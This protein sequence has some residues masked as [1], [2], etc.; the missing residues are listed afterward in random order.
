MSLEHP[1]RFKCI[2]VDLVVTLFAYPSSFCSVGGSGALFP[3]IVLCDVRRDTRWC[4]RLTP[5]VRLR[6]LPASIPAK[7]RT[8][9]ARGLDVL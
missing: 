6:K 5:C 4:I 3:G 2:D 7:F 1:A 8:A 9:L